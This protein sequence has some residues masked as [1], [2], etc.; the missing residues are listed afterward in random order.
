[1]DQTT[2]TMP[3]PRTG[4]FFDEGLSGLGRAQPTIYRGT[5][6]ARKPQNFRHADTDLFGTA[7]K[8]LLS[9]GRCSYFIDGCC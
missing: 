4:T 3:L 6:I 5:L 9:V 1:M 8:H 2:E 7:I